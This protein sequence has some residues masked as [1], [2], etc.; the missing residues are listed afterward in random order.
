MVKQHQKVSAQTQQE[1]AALAKQNQKPGQTKAQTKLIE[2]GIQKGI[3]QYKKAQKAKARE[4]SKQKKQ[5]QKQQTTATNNKV[6]DDSNQQQST[7]VPWILLLLSWLGF[8]AYLL[9]A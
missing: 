9:L 3:E 5:K 2:Q 1:A 6:E 4:L 8:I 7:S